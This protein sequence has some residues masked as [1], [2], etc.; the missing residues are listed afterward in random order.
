MSLYAL[1]DLVDAGIRDIAI[2]IG[3]IFPEKVKEFFGN[4]DRFGAKIT[5]IY[6]DKPGGIAQAIGLCRDFVKDDDFVVYLGDNIL[7]GG[8]RNFAV[9][10]RKSNA[11][12]LIL[13]CEVK[14]ASRFGIATIHGSEITRIVEKPKNP[15]SNLAIIGIYFLKPTIFEIIGKLKPSWRGELEITEA[16]QGLLISRKKIEYDYVTGWWKDTGT[17]TDVL[18]ANRFILDN[19]TTKIEGIVESD[20]SIQGRI[21][22]GNNSKVS[23]GATI[24]GPVIIGKNCQI[25]TG[26]YIGPYTSIGDN[27]QIRNGS[28]ENSIVLNDCKID[29]HTRIVD[30]IIGNNT[31]LGMGGN[32][33]PQGLRLIIGD[34]STVYL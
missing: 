17:P 25:G 13:L 5:Y 24:R 7:K 18:D 1:E 11:D 30:S 34:S 4:G 23:K 10:F 9:K 15:E 2:V 26:V 32:T 22:L 28:I 21:V 33:H 31:I 12:A 16:L 19:I 20:E 3:D 27:V 29:I 14:D 6:Q 8:I